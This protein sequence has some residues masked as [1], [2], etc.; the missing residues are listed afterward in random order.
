[1]RLRLS[2]NSEGLMATQYDRQAEDLGNV[3]MLE[4]VKL[5]VPDQVTRI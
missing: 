2:A 3:V 5:Q 1:M 4:H